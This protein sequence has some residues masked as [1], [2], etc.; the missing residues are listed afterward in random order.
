MNNFNKSHSGSSY[1]P[2][3]KYYSERRAA[4]EAYREEQ[5]EQDEKVSRLKKV[6]GVG[7]AAIFAVTLANGGGE[8]IANVYKDTQPVEEVA[9]ERVKVRSGD[10]A[11]SYAK[12]AQEDIHEY[13]ERH[14][15]D[16]VRGD[17]SLDI[18]RT[19]IQNDNPDKNIGELQPGDTLIIPDYTPNES[20]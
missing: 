8:A 5:C 3:E 9:T 12:D 11:W 4:R 1:Q 2:D 14:P 10:T 15:D 13:N 7:V 6:I 20:D 16:P 19:D 17:D 18:I